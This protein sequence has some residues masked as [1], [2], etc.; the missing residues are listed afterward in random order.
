MQVKYEALNQLTRLLGALIE[1]SPFMNSVSLRDKVSVKVLRHNCTF[2]SSGFRFASVGAGGG[3]NV[4]DLNI[5]SA[6]YS[7][8]N[9]PLLPLRPFGWGIKTNRLGGVEFRHD[10][11]S[12]NT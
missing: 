6:C 9:K 5:I 8:P 4:K 1:F 11:D 12:R 3:S 2:G 7:K 10:R